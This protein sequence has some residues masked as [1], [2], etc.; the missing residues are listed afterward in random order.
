MTPKAT[1]IWSW[2][3][4]QLFGASLQLGSG[5]AESLVN[6]LSPEEEE[7][8]NRYSNRLHRERFIFRRALLRQLLAQQTGRTARSLQFVR[9][10]R[11][12]P[13]LSNSQVEFSVSS[14]N[15]QAVFLLSTA[16]AV[17]VD[18][19]RIVPEF[20]YQSLLDEHFTATERD[21]ILKLQP[22]L[23]IPAFYRSW[24]QKEACAKAIGAGLTVP[25]SNYE[26]GSSSQTWT[27]AGPNLL[28]QGIGAGEGIAVAVAL[29]TK[30]GL[31][32]PPRG[33]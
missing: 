15:E 8:S 18:I 22:S 30:G 2:G 5:E 33:T 10:S 26:V 25:L 19:E 1:L 7:V 14:S 29:Q 16:G 4:I 28:V 11:G 13:S 20:A 12:K 21:S 17:G 6:Y 23:R 31:K 27:P 3:G 9:E 24:T 32:D